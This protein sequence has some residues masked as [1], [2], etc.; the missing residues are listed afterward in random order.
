M[1][2]NHFVLDQWLQLEK[3][4]QIAFFTLMI[5]PPPFIIPLF[6]QNAEESERVY[7]TNALA[8]STVVSLT[9]FAIY[10]GM[11]PTL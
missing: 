11:H 2:L 10:L 8:V 4:F 5:L 7:V 3:P 1:L 6:M 9:I